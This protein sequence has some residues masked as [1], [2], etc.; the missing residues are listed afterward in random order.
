[1]IYG[2]LAIPSIPNV[3]TQIAGWIVVI[4]AI[5]SIIMAIFGK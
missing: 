1:M 5:I 2:T 4:G 3:I